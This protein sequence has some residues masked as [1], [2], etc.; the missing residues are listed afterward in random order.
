NKETAKKATELLKE[1][2]ELIKYTKLISIEAPLS[3]VSAIFMHELIV[4]Y[5]KEFKD[6][7]EEKIKKLEIELENLK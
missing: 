6:V 4:K 7:I 2:D 5:K 3:Q 1:I